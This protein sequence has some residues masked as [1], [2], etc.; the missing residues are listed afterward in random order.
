[1]KLG[2]LGGTF[3]PLHNGH[4]QMAYA[5]L[6]ELGLD[7]VALIPTG[8][9]PHKLSP[10]APAE[11]RF[12]MIMQETMEDER[13]ILLDMELRRK[14]VTYT[15]DT[16]RELTSPPYSNGDL[17][18]TYIIGTDTLLQLTKWREYEQV[19]TLADFFVVPRPG[20]DA[21]ALAKAK[22][23]L[24]AQ[25]ARIT[26]S[27]TVGID[28]SSSQ[29]REK[30][31]REEY[32]GLPIPAKALTE[33]IRSNPYKNAI[34]RENILAYIKEKLP[35]KRFEHTLRVEQEAAILADIWQ[36]DQQQ[37]SIA[38]LLHDCARWQTPTQ[39]CSMAELYRTLNPND[40]QTLEPTLLHAGNGAYIAEKEFGIEDKQIL[41]AIACHTLG[42]G[43]M[44]PLERI[45]YIADYIEPGRN[46]EELSSLRQVAYNSLDDACFLCA[47]QTI[48]YNIANFKVVHPATLEMYNY[49]AFNAKN[50]LQKNGGMYPWLQKI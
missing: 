18:L 5:A 22:V 17:S 38:A 43:E 47:G 12:A 46:R 41:S 13:L 48:T 9:P 7:K 2:V 32:E 35:Q 45:I 21:E 28:I 40:V 31:A 24:E 37:T 44:T 39:A 15:I 30:L 23:T 50:S 16:L 49:Y 36:I 3:D 33:L 20:Y 4:M 42:K 10:L 27:K 11:V 1:M 6:D 8:H 34:L 26:I 19:L 29:L 25:G 14:N